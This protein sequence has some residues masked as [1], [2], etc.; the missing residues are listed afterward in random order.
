MHETGI[1]SIHET[2]PRRLVRRN[3][4]ETGLVIGDGANMKKR[5]LRRSDEDPVKLPKRQTKEQRETG[6]SCQVMPANNRDV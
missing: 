3:Q 6:R 4:E 1:F 5:K 2:P